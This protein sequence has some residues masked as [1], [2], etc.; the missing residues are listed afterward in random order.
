MRLNRHPMISFIRNKILIYPVENENPV[1]AVRH[2]H[3]IMMQNL[4]NG[5]GFFF[6]LEIFQ[7]DP[8]RRTE[9]VPDDFFHFNQP[10]FFLSHFGQFIAPFVTELPIPYPKPFEIFNS[11]RLLILT[12]IIHIIVVKKHILTANS[13]NAQLA[14]DLCAISL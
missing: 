5:A 2:K 7:P 1:L 6:K 11:R 3:Q 9:F 10:I 13:S 8:D 12:T 14:I 4:F